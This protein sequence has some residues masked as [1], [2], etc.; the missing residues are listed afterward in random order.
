MRGHLVGWRETLV[1]AVSQLQPDYAITLDGTAWS[2]VTPYWWFTENYRPVARFGHATIYQRTASSSTGYIANTEAY[3]SSGLILTEAAVSSQML[4][5][6]GTLAIHLKFD[7][8]ASQSADYQ[9]TTYLM[10]AQTYERFAITNEWPFDSG[11]STRFWQAREQFQVPLRLNVPRDLKPGTYRLGV[12]VYNPATHTDLPLSTNASE[13]HVGWL[14]VG[15][16]K[17]TEPSIPLAEKLL[18]SAW[19]EGIKLT[20]IGL[21]S[22]TLSAGEMLVVAFNWRVDRVPLRDLTVFLH[23]IDNAGNIVAQKDQHPFDGRFSTAVWQ[24]DEHLRDVFTVA[25]PANL[26]AGKY[27]LRIGLYDMAGPVPLDNGS[28]DF[29]LLPDVVQVSTQ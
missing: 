2:G 18:N 7:V 15:N 17:S 23:V 27:G 19:S 6:G 14:R 22:R 5:P 25:L 28:Q 12:I 4:Q 10:D 29:L 16:P 9:L 20:A 21:P 26:P 8:A 3:F 11:Y 13:V 24:V 1:Y